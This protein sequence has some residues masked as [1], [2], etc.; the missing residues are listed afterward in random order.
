MA[1][2]SMGCMVK[3]E[4]VLRGEYKM[5]SLRVGWRFVKGVE[6]A[7]CGGGTDVELH[8]SSRSGRLFEN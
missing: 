3:R 1:N 8:S 5:G 7:R 2:R 6:E 4:N